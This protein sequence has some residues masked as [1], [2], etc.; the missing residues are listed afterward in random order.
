MN[1]KII[2]IDSQCVSYLIDAMQNVEEPRGNL[3]PEKIALFRTYLYTPGTLYVTPTVTKECAAIRNTEQNELHKSYILT[4]IGE[5]QI[6]NQINIESRVQELEIYHNGKNDCRILAEAEEAEYCV[7]LSYDNN[8]LSRLK[9]IS[10]SVQLYRPSEY[11]S[12]LNI[13]RGAKP[14]KIPH[15][16]NPMFLQ[17]WWKW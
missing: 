1:T 16:T 17:T 9:A 14:D 6:Q 3:A 2:G 13:E 8:F 5:S 12:H 10:S 7:L 4:L 11:W 15:K